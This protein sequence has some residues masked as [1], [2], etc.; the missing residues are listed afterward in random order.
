M[1]F[2]AGLTL[3]AALVSAGPVA[4][5]IS[6]RNEPL[7]I[8]LKRV[9]NT[10]IKA[11]LKNAGDEPLK[12]FTAGTFLD[13]A[14]V[15][16]LTVLSDSQP[17][18]FD[19][20]RLRL[21]PQKFITDASFK[22]L[23][24]GQTV[25]IELDFAQMHDLGK[26]TTFEVFASGGIPYANAGSTKISGVINYS[27]NTLSVKDVDSAKAAFTRLSFH[28]EI[29]RTIVQADCT[30]KN[31]T[32]VMAALI[33]CQKMARAAANTAMT[34]DKR[35]QEYFKVSTPEAKQVVFNTFSRVASECSRRDRGVSKQY[36]SDVYASCSPGVL[37]YT[38]PA[39]KYMVNCPLYFS[40]LP[41]L[42][43][44]CHAQD[45][46]TTTLHEMTHL[47]QVKGT[48]DYGIYGY[49]A[50]KTLKSAE[51]LNHAD[52]YCLFANAVNIG[53]TC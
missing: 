13:T 42:T 35:M 52:T 31:L 50:I 16:K 11:T 15:E 9:G 47:L 14:A 43:K 5:D 27:S 17:V 51:N 18:P 21:A 4:V 48:L 45:Q 26:N 36:C 10:G 25:N 41:G 22:T 34:D 6:K 39:L 20:V 33:N 24:A 37:A 46:A 1:R 28:N 38:V 8:V 49:D 40:A 53:K 2:F 12:L 32:A 30:G 23:K 3:L 44:T 7:E 19:G 29:K